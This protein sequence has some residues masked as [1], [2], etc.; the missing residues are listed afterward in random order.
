MVDLMWTYRRTEEPRTR[1]WET[2]KGEPTSHVEMLGES[3]LQS[4]LG[5]L[6]EPVLSVQWKSGHSCPQSLPIAPSLSLK[7]SPS[8]DSAF[9][10]DPLSC[11]HRLPCPCSR[12]PGSQRCKNMPVWPLARGPYASVLSVWTALLPDFWFSIP[13]DHYTLSVRPPLPSY[14][15]S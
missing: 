14:L 6:P 13:S 2:R 8:S 4:M 10:N 9:L 7:Q 12:S 1:A 15:K 3:K 11:S 5:S